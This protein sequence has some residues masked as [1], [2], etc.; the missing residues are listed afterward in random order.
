MGRHKDSFIHWLARVT[1]R[2][3]LGRAIEF[4][5]GTR[6][7]KGRFPRV[8]QNMTKKWAQYELGSENPKSVNTYYESSSILRHRKS[9]HKTVYTTSW[10]EA[11]HAERKIPGFMEEVGL[12]KTK[13]ELAEP[14]LSTLAPS[15]KALAKLRGY[16]M[17]PPTAEE[18]FYILMKLN[19]HPDDIWPEELSGDHCHIQILSKIC[20]LFVRREEVFFQAEEALFMDICCAEGAFSN[21]AWRRSVENFLQPIIGTISIDPNGT[22][23][24]FMHIVDPNHGGFSMQ[25]DDK[26]F[27]TIKKN[28]KAQHI[29]WKEFESHLK[30]K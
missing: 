8:E 4:L 9:D 21:D 5:Y 10:K 17:E 12:V 22:A 1:A 30:R 24:K 28:G 19:I 20:A 27:L 29:M 3:N 7:P 6:S 13:K 18:A 14:Y 26:M 2:A 15:D 16:N 23:K 11:V 25:V